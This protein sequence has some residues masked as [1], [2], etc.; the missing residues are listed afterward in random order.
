[1]KLWG[2]IVGLSLICMSLSACFSNIMTGIVG[3]IPY[4]I[5]VLTDVSRDDNKA[6]LCMRQY[7]LENKHLL[8]IWL[9]CAVSL[10]YSFIFNKVSK[11]GK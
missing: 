8:Y 10:L 6:S 1:M 11:S 7:A 3:S 5:L 9:L 4:P 2:R